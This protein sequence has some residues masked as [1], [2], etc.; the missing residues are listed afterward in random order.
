MSD[1]LQ[2]AI[3]ASA[4][5][6]ELPTGGSGDCISLSD[7]AEI[8]IRHHQS[9]H[10]VEAEALKM[11][12]HPQR[13][14]RNMNDISAASQVQ[15][16]E[17]SVAQVGL[18]GL[19]GSLLEIFL[20]TG[21]G[22]IRGADG[23]VFE[24]SNLN[25]QAL[26]SPSNLGISKAHAARDRAQAIN[27]SVDF[28]AQDTFLDDKSLPEFLNGCD[29]AIDA[30]GGLDMRRSLQQAATDAGIPLVTGALA[31]WTGYV[32]VVMP[33]QTGPADI[34]GIN[35]AAEEALG[36]PAAAVTC[37]ASIM[38]TE[39]I[40]TLTQASSLKGKM[41]IIDLKSLSFETIII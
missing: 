10:V 17:S 20:R 9:G 11:G 19:G 35:N 3:Q 21:I 23:D 4:V 15:L 5:R 39:T 22:R 28:A 1:S 41:L 36:C 12:I 31:G 34:M 26:S 18:G 8:A 7:V 30:L 32:G 40:K 33:G 2:S 29:I 37:I 6:Q 13:Y 38:A 16:L 24:E 27:P 14:L 25:R